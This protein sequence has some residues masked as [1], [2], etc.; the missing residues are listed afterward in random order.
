MFLLRDDNAHRFEVQNK[1]HVGR[2]SSLLSI[3][4]QIASR[5][6]NNVIVFVIVF[7]DSGFHHAGMFRKRLLKCNFE[8]D[9][10]MIDVLEIGLYISDSLI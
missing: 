2:H 9:K 1:V 3:S 6:K 8:H 10:M 5:E 7:A 4:T